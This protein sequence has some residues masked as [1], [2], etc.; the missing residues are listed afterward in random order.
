MRP[1]SAR[2]KQG[3]PTAAADGGS[4]GRTLSLRIL[5]S[6]CSEFPPPHTACARSSCF[7]RI[8]L[9]RAYRARIPASWASLSPRHPGRWLA[10]SHEPPVPAPRT[11]MNC[12]NLHIQDQACLGAEFPGAFRGSASGAPELAGQDVFLSFCFT[13]LHPS[14]PHSGSTSPPGSSTGIEHAARKL[15]P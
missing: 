12:K 1:H 14:T 2:A 13:N 10:A 5:R 8:F 4:R 15:D 7:F 6:F 9:R 11:G 3:A